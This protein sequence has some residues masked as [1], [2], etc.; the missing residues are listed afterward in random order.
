MSEVPV[1][2]GFRDEE[3]D[4]RDETK[5]DRQINILSLESSPKNIYSLLKSLP[6][7]VE[8]EV[9]TREPRWRGR[10]GMKTSFAGDGL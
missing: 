10:S 8:V 9:A 3:A 5:A 6:H 2:N 1:F 4:W 7:D